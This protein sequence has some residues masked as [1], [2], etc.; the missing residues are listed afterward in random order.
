MHDAATQYKVLNNED[1]LS[2]VKGAV[3]VLNRIFPLLLEEKEMFI[4][5]M[6]RE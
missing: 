2:K 5:C 6:W 4:R 3:H 1:L